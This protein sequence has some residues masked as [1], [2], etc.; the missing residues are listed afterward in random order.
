MNEWM[1][2]LKQMTYLSLFI[3]KKDSLFVSVDRH[4]NKNWKLYWD[5]FQQYLST[6]EISYGSKCFS[7][8]FKKY[9]GLLHCRSHLMLNAYSSI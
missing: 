1:I 2:S 3:W 7:E 8:A 4:R 5:K 6:E 9:L